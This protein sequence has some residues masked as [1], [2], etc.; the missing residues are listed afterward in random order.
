MPSAAPGTSRLSALFTTSARPRTAAVAVFLLFAYVY[1]MNAWA[2]EDAYIS[3]RTVENWVTGHGLTWNPGERV[4]AFTH[5][6]W[7]FVMA[8]ARAITSEIYLTSIA[9]T[10]L[11]SLAALAVLLRA[12]G[13]RP[14]TILLLGSLIVSSKAFI[15]YS[16]SGLE[17]ALAYC[18]CA[19]FFSSVLYGIP[20]RDAPR[21][22]DVAASFLLGALLFTTRQDLVLLVIPS[23]AGL[24][25]SHR[26]LGWRRIAG[27]AL[28]GLAPALAWEA[29]SIIYYGFPFPNSA[30]AKLNTGIA[31][32]DLLRQAPWYFW[33]SLSWDFVT[34]ATA[35]FALAHSLLRGPR[36]RRDAAAGIL[37]YLLYILRIG[38]DFMSGRF[39]A[40][41]FLASCL[42]LAP[43]RFTRA[44]AAGVFA[45]LIAAFIAMPAPP[46]KSTR[47]YTSLGIDGHGIADERGYY[48][49]EAGLLNYT[50]DGVYP[51]HPWMLSG[52]E[53]R[54]RTNPGAI[55][56]MVGYYGYASGPRKV[57]IDRFG[58]ADPLLAR[59][60]VID[61]KNWRIGHFERPLP[62]G[63]VDSFRARRNLIADPQLSLFYDK[64]RL[65]IA[66][67]LWAQER[68]RAIW[69]INTG[70]YDDLVRGYLERAP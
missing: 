49:Q 21:V 33:N 29:F 69:T 37:L 9:T 10:F 67:P 64:I 8:A 62:E 70:G 26:R 3:F 51:N 16:S 61:P 66:G 20:R 24:S 41:P 58:L 18:L 7:V 23:L 60:P 2:A 50:A 55:T 65:I 6:L 36:P 52:L 39:F 13:P 40:V 59:L 34:L 31:A 42:L 47:S 27:A 30:Y 53:L 54:D 45:V 56:L 12:A 63:Y 43:V 35:A 68:L 11:L 46:L 19:L 22:R 1:A 14:M 38:G 48:F 28:L 25:V 44:A 5:P 32:A 57:V 17:N 15:D 4:Q